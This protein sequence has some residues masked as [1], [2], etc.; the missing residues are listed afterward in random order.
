MDSLS[1]EV[2]LVVIASLFLLLVATGIIALMMVYGRKQAAYRFEQTQMRAAF[3]KELLQAQLEMQERTLQ[4][5][6]RE[7][8]DNVNQTLTLANLHLNAASRESANGTTEKITDTKKLLEKARTDLR[9]LSRTLNP[10][11]VLAEGFEK[12]IETELGLIGNTA[13]FTTGFTVTGEPIELG[14]EKELLLF[15]TVQEALQNSIKHSGAR[16]LQVILNYQHNGL[17]LLIEDDGR[18][19]P[20]SASGGSGLHNMRHRTKMI[21]G[22][23]QIDGTAGT[24]IQISV[25][26]IVA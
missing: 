25:P 21:G 13:V 24:R 9:N 6:A 20:P 22:D 15:R 18:G 7:V 4:H 2:G 12:A 3:E 5:V 10:E 26:I 8:H 14:P 16:R 19:L 1:Q 23:L 17:R 11:A